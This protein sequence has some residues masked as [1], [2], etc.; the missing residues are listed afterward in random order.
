[1][2]NKVWNLDKVCASSIA[3]YDISIHLRISLLNVIL[4]AISQ[5]GEQL[6]V[7][8]SAKVQTLQA[9]ARV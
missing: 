1:M 2:N 3:S 6:L 8:C 4:C 7:D 9:D 5:A